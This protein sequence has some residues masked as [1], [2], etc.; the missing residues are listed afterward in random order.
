MRAHS[1]QLHKTGSIEIHTELYRQRRPWWL[2]FLKMLGVAAMVAVGAAIA[3]PTLLEL[4]FPLWHASVVTGVGMIA[5]TAIAFFFRPEANTDN[6]GV[7]GG[8]ANDPF[9]CGDNVNRFLWKAHCVLGPGRFTAETFLDILV[10]VRLLKTGDEED[11]A[12]ADHVAFPAMSSGGAFDATRPIA[13]LDPNR[14][15]QTSGNFV[16][17]QIQLDSQ[18]FFTS[19]SS[20]L[21]TAGEPNRV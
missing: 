5:Y 20:S 4:D 18:K 17:G 11:P 14:F 7:G 2:V 9:Q 15:A 3:V 1:S 10:L 13:P 19:A 16:A 8:M 12:A 6:M 21:P